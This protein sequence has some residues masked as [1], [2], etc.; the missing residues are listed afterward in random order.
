MKSGITPI[1]DVHNYKIIKGHFFYKQLLTI[2]SIISIK[3]H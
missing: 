3:D 1:Q 2:K